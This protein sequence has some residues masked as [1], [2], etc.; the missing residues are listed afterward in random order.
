[1]SAASDF[2]ELNILKAITG[3]AAFP[4]PGFTYVALHTS[5]PGEA[6]GAN[7]VST[8]D[9][10]SYA[11]KKAEGAGAIGSGWSSP[12][13]NVSQG[14]ETKNINIL[15]YSANNGVATVTVTHWSIWDAVT[16]G[17]MILAKDLTVPVAINVADIFVFDANS[18]TL[19][20][21]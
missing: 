15:A 16:G 9:W 18:L 19:T 11:R 3:Q 5:S 12:V 10:P 14:K 1:M 20:A 7:E 17:N 13:D 8:G 2:T 6:S 4:A 21:S